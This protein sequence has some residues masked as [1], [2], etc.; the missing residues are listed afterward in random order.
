MQDLFTRGVLPTGVARP[1]PASEPDLYHSL[2][3]RIVPKS[4]REAELQDIAQVGRGKF[5]HR[6][7][8]D[9]RF[10]G[11]AFPFIQTGD[12]AA[13]A[14]DYL[15]TYSQTLSASGA[16]VSSCFPTGTIAVTI[17]ANIADTAILSIPMYFPDSVVGVVVTG[18]ADVRFVELSIRRSKPRLEAMAPQSA[19]KNINLQDLRPL[20]L[21]LP[22]LEEQQAISARYEA[23]HRPIKAL[24]NGLAKL[25]AQKLGLMQD[26]LTGKVPV[27]VP[28]PALPA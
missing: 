8:N 22:P 5:T 11:G 3:G 27:T 21:M 10:L 14:G 28:E 2:G 19:Q 6:P 12:I 23:A 20:K 17:A 18:A 7:R 16:A 9:P 25:R 26:L 13:A 1:E 15:D 4:W 24:R